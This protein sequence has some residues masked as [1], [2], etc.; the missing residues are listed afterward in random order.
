MM[1]FIIFQLSW[2]LLHFD[3]LICPISYDDE[4][5]RMSMECE[6][7]PVFVLTEYNYPETVQALFTLVCHDL[8]NIFHESTNLPKLLNSAL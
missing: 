3:Y 1:M 5:N 8:F 2:A 4:T 6:K 7:N